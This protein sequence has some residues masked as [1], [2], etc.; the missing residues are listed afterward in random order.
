MTS[1]ARRRTQRA[2]SARRAE[3]ASASAATAP[4]PAA[5]GDGGFGV[6]RR[7]TRA[8]AESQD[9]LLAEA[10]ALV[11]GW[12]AVVNPLHGTVHSSPRGAGPAAVGAATRP[13]AYP[14]LLTRQ[15]AGAVL[16]LGPGATAHA[17]H[18]AHVP[19]ASDPADAALVADTAAD[20]LRVRSR[21]ADDAEQRLHSA[22]LRLLL[23]GQRQLAAELL[24]GTSATHAT[25]YRLTGDAVRAAH[26]ELWREALPGAGTGASTGPV[27]ALVCRYGTDELVVVALHGAH[28]EQHAMLSL[29]ARAADRHELT[30]GVSDPAPLDMIGTAWA[31]A[32]TARDSA[33]VGCLTTSL[34]A[35]ELLHVVPADRLAAWSGAVLMPLHREQRRTLEAWLRAG[36]AH[37]AAPVLGVSEGT[38]RAR[39]PVIAS[40][41]AADLDH[42]T[43]QAQLLLALRAPAA[44]SAPTV[45]PAPEPPLPAGL[46]SPEEA[47][48]WATTLLSPLDTQLRIAV[49]CWLRHRGRTAPAA[50]EL[51]VHRETLTAWLAKCGRLLDLDL[52]S[53]TVRAELHLA[54][55]TLATPDDVPAKLPRRGGRTY[56]GPRW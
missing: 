40:L 44:P 2:S 25:V 6:V 27:P 4:S 30:G 10:A 11:D 14:R 56:R 8:A 34:G 17:S 12:A 35:H 18:S 46:L 5:P 21:R 19:H 28:D 42:P 50:A 22:V 39:L 7:L 24:G 49:R 9:A 51:G 32:G 37:A 29:M 47:A 16:V 54:A 33:A 1:D 52:S 26:R 53:P 15:V 41:L 13:H 43:V 55:E 45:R 3:P 36:S 31:E 20:L 48:R 23:R 38:V